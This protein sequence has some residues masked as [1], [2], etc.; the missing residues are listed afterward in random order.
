MIDYLFFEAA[1]LE[2][3]EFAEMIDKKEIG[4]S[5]LPCEMYPSDH[6]SLYAKF[7]FMQ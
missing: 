6:M 2:M 4:E 5:G 3:L 7:A 1:A